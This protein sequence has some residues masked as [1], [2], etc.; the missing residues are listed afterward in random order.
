MVQFYGAGEADY[1]QVKAKILGHFAEVDEWEPIEY[2]RQMEEGMKGYHDLVEYGRRE[3]Y[4]LE[5]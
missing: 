2:V 5:N 3:I 4:K 1:S